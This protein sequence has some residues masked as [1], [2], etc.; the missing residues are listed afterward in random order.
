[1]RRIEKY[2]RW[3]GRCTLAWL[4]RGARMLTKGIKDGEQ[5]VAAAGFILSEHPRL[6]P[7]AVSSCRLQQQLP[8]LA[9]VKFHCAHFCG[10][11]S[12]NHLLE[13]L[14]RL[15]RIGRTKHA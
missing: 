13:L 6:L 12:Q 7:R 3:R 2:G 9:P 14:L 8:H 5:P 15:V 4:Q 11:S 1:M 10:A